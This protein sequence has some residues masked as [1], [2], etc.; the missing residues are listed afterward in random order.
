MLGHI[1]V[2]PLGLGPMT[3]RSATATRCRLQWR[4]AGM[5]LAPGSGRAV[6]ADYQH[7]VPRTV[8][9]HKGGFGIAFFSPF[10][11]R[12]HF[13]A[14]AGD[15]GVAAAPVSIHE[16]PVFARYARAG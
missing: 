11:N 10:S 13:S 14:V 8:R 2:S 1:A 16:T 15:R 3:I 7:R 12:R 6:G 9:R 4:A 5:L